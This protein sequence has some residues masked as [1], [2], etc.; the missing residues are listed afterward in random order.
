MRDLYTLV[1]SSVCQLFKK[2]LPTVNLFGMRK[3]YVKFL[4]GFLLCLGGEVMG[5]SATI[6]LRPDQ[7]D[8]AFT[9][10][11]S[12]V[13]VTSALYSSNDARYRI[14]NGAFQYDCWDGS[15]YVS[16]TNYASGPH[17]PGT[18]ITTS[19]WWI[20]FQRGNNNSVAGSYRD[21][22]GPAYGSNYQT[23]ALPAATAV[24]VTRYSLTGT[25]TACASPSYPLT[26]KYVVLAFDATSGGN[27]VV[28]GST[29]LTTGTFNIPVSSTITIRR[30]EIRTLSNIIL[31]TLTGIWNTSTNI[32]TS[33]SLCSGTNYYWNGNNTSVLNGTWNNTDNNWTSPTATATPNIAW[34]STGTSNIANFLTGSGVVTLPGTITSVPSNTI[35][36]NNNFS[37]ASSTT[38]ALASP[39]A[40]GPNTLTITPAIGGSINLSGVISGAGGLSFNGSGATTLSGTNTFTG[41]KT[42]SNG[43]LNIQSADALG[44]SGNFNIS[45]GTINNTSGS[46]ITTPSYTQSWAGD[47]SF[48]G[49]NA[50][51]L[52]TGAVALT[53]NRQIT[54]NA[55]TLTVGGGISGAFSLTKAG[56]GELLLSGTSTYS[57]GTIINAGTIT[58][59]STTTLL[60]IGTINLNGGTL[61]S[62]SSTG[63][64]ETMGTL[65]LSTNSTISLG[66]GN[67]ALTFANSTT[68][69][70]T[71]ATLLTIN[72]WT[73]TA[74]AS[75]SAGKIFVG[76]GGLNAGQLGQIRFTGFPGTPI[77]LASGEVVPPGLPQ[78]W[79]ND[80]TGIDPG[81]A[82]PYTTGDIFNPDITVSGISRGSGISGNAG[83]NRYNANG[84]DSPGLDQNDYFEFT[85]TPITGKTIN[86]INFI[87]NG[88]RSATGASS[89]AI[90]SSIDGFSTDIGLV[91]VTGNTVDLS[92]IKYQNVFCPITF[93]IYGWGGTNSGGT[94]GIEDF[95]FNG[96][97]ANVGAAALTI[98]NNGT[99]PAANIYLSTTNNVFSSFELT[100]NAS[101]TFSAVT[102]KHTGTATAADVSNVRIF[103]DQ[104]SNGIIDG[105][106]AIVPGATVASLAAS[107]TF[108][109]STGQ[110]FMCKRNYLVVGDVSGTA[111]FGRTVITSIAVSADVSSTITTKTGNA[112]GNIQTIRFNSFASDYF[113]SNVVLGSWADP[114]SWESSH[115]NV[116]FYMASLAPT[117]SA[118]SIIIRTGHHIDISTA[119]VSMTNT[120]VQTG[121]VLE[122]TTNS[123]FEVEGSG[124]GRNIQLTIKTGADFLVNSPGAFANPTGT[125]AGMV[126]TGGRVIAGSAINSGGGTPFV[127]AYIGYNNGLFYFQNNAICEWQSANTVLGSSSPTDSD[128]FFPDNPSDLTLFRITT[129]PLWPFGSNAADNTFFAILE[130]NANFDFQGS[131]NKTFIGGIR[132]TALITQII[133]GDLIIGNGTNVPV[134]GGSVTLNVLNNGFSLPN[135]ATVPTGANVRIISSSEDNWIKKAKG[136]LT[137]N[138]TLDV[139]DMRLQN[140]NKAG[141]EINVNGTLK[142]GNKDGLIGP[143]VAAPGATTIT[144]PSTFNLNTGST[145]E[146]NRNGDQAISTT[147]IYDSLTLSS[148]GTK[149]PNNLV[150]LISKLKITGATTVVDAS[151]NNIGNT[152]ANTTKL[153][154]DAGLF[155]LGTSETLPLM[156][157]DYNI[158]GGIIRY[159]YTGATTQRIRNPSSGKYQNIE[160]TGTNVSNSSTVPLNTGGTFTVANGGI[161]FMRDFSITGD[162]V[163]GQETVTVKN[164]GRFKTENSKGFHGFTATFTDYS[165]IHSNVEN[166][167]LEPGSTVEYSRD[168]A[169]SVIGDQ[170]ISNAL[171]TNNPINFTYQNLEV[172]GTNIKTAPSTTL[173]IAGNLTKTSTSIFKHNGGTVLFNGS[174][175][176]TFSNNSG[177]AMVFNNVTNQS[178]GN[179]LTIN[180]DSFAIT[181]K[182]LLSGGSLLK[183]GSGNIILK[184]SDTLTANVAAIPNEAGII[185]YPGA[186]RFTTERYIKYTG[187][188]NLLTAP[189]AESGVPQSIKE[190]WQ[191][192][193]LNYISTGYG[194]QV[195]MPAPIGTGLD[196]PS[197]GY[198][199]KWWNPQTN[200]FVGVN[201][202]ETTFA[203]QPN[204]FFAFVRGD[205]SISPG[206]VGGPAILR[207][208]GKLYVAN[209]GSGIEPP[210]VTHTFTS[211]FVFFSVANPFASAINFESVYNNSETKNITPNYYLWDPTVSGNYNVGK[212]QTFAGAVN[213]L[214]T[215]G[216]GAGL[217]VKD[218]SYDSIQSGQA[219]YV[220]SDLKDIAASVKF[221]ESNK[222]DSSRTVTRGGGPESL[223]MMS[224]MLHNNAGQ[225]ADGNRVVFDNVY[226]KDFAKEDAR[227][228]NNSGENFGI[229]VGSYTA[230][231]EGRPEVHEND[232]IFYK[233]SNLLTANYKLSFEPRNL[234]GTGLQAFIIDKFLNSS[235]Q[236][237]LTDSSW[238]PFA[239]TA[240]AASKAANRFMLVFKAAGGPLPVTL[241]QILAKRNTDQSITVTWKVEQEQQVSHYE[242]ERSADGLQFTKL[243]TAAAT[244]ANEYTQL[245]AQPLLADNYYRI[246]AVSQNGSLQYS[247]IVKVVPVQLIS[248]LAVFPNPVVK[249]Q[250]HIQL[251]TVKDANYKLQLYNIG[252]QLVFE[253]AIILKAGTQNIN[254]SLPKYISKGNYR[255]NMQEPGGV[256]LAEN[257]ILE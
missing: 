66:T 146:Y 170:E 95:T 38:A 199:I 130:A 171:T 244:N 116:S 175:G 188:W 77:I 140:I 30:V 99:P 190:S 11:E 13:L 197:P 106:D 156:R 41:L 187:N 82:S 85:L 174:A 94:Y 21:R 36:G 126:E 101:Q 207:S 164:G 176:Q 47:F 56:A 25:V 219:F 8:L 64:S 182:L 5:Q 238:Y 158:T 105:A 78:L 144:S 122:I 166:I 225:V 75:G 241:T 169:N 220:A 224:T 91:Y 139:T 70:W 118:T 29:N 120:T 111:S 109:F 150:N 123:S 157:G 147:V 107:M 205:R 17:I 125:G 211:P 181:R 68:V 131:N 194:T 51:N 26:D 60:N 80:I 132:G 248:S 40:L 45:G 43:T 208:K 196:N 81:L 98:S 203:N 143:S 246:K 247:R 102:I 255:L 152:G 252:G 27:L 163:S 179:G 35:I 28:A 23:T 14:Y 62:G 222:A 67:H 141:D 3:T 37:F 86:F 92:N 124:G 206:N 71:A 46:A 254:I 151:S 204:G 10:S 215:P 256:G 212:Y 172:S 89:F 189:V 237:S 161:Y 213:W 93:R 7:I 193:G 134:L 112:I 61:K 160:I 216:S 49:S 119:G 88:S 223:V 195:T 242:I 177:F 18:P 214:P 48:T 178:S 180:S 184:S 155:I 16:S 72:G 57:G 33:I 217:Y 136:I 6:T 173:S 250:L 167:V 133:G 168:I 90:R 234:T 32:G 114:V 31:Q 113:R 110:I 230:I 115:D 58:L 103:W 153:V 22:L 251:T 20:I 198:S 73:G 235:T 226:S 165:S 79:T 12:A 231:V 34:P 148:G 138:G 210:G 232:T 108:T 253:K 185:S 19:S 84:W 53:A 127:D 128:F 142:T 2:P 201:N 236:I 104:N 137:V 249:Q 52:G 15:A 162:N 39:I 44:A 87:Y 154:M 257:I 9:T 183:L 218:H 50:L 129:S 63:F 191:E 96:T 243:A 117:S 192:G 159:T 1:C 145:I 55:S 200:A 227:K 209:T 239:A 4:L 149:T 221:S 65:K 121:G 97:T 100:A 228:I 233:M 76:A 135:G 42:L 54:T 74:G 229:T 240:D 83:N 202:T 186:G 24:S 245:D 59:G 69:S